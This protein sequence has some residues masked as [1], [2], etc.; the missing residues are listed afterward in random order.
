MGKKTL[1]DKS[2]RFKNGMETLRTQPLHENSGQLIGDMIQFKASK[3]V[4]IYARTWLKVYRDHDYAPNLVG[5]WLDKLDSNE[6]MYWAEYY[7]RTESKATN[8]R[9]LLRAIGNSKR[10]PRRIYD[11]IEARME[12]EPLHD[13]W[14]CLQRFEGKNQ[15]RAEKI[16]LRWLE[17]NRKNRDMDVI[18]SV[19][20]VFSQSI[21]ILE[22]ALMWAEAVENSAGYYFVLGHLLSGNTDAHKTLMSRTAAFTRRWIKVHSKDPNCGRVYGRLISGVCD[23]NDIR[24]A[25][26]WFKHHESNPSAEWV[27]IGLLSASSTLKQEPD[28]YVVKKVKK[29]LRKQSPDKRLPVMESVLF[30]VCQDSETIA[31]VRQTCVET[32][33]TS[34]L[35]RL[36]LVAPAEDLIVIAKESFEK[37]RNINLER[38]LLTALLRQN[39][40]DVSLRESARRWLRKHGKKFAEAKLEPLRTALSCADGGTTFT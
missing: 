28:P 40:A 30:N 2:I 34:V 23:V 31:I 22:S 17:L 36:L 20:A 12:A 27:L 14:S 24:D 11:L 10:S 39:S 32:K 5:H 15:R 29:I 37:S 8:L 16:I 7:L 38:D 9:V 6:A 18:V 21:E 26:D 3:S 1:M 33:S 13:A 25:K 35:G 4:L 19:V